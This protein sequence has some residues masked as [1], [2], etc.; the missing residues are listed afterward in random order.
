MKNIP[1]YCVI[2]T[3]KNY[4]YK[5]ATNPELHAGSP[6]YASE[7]TELWD[8]IFKKP[9]HKVRQELKQISFTS[10]READFDKVYWNLD[11]F[12]DDYE[13][14]KTK[15]LVY[16]QDDDDL[17]VPDIATKIKH[18][19]RAGFDG[20]VWG[21]L[22]LHGMYNYYFTDIEKGRFGINDDGN[23]MEVRFNPF[24]F[25]QSNHNVTLYPI[26][27][28][29]TIGTH[30]P[31][32]DI[33]LPINHSCIH[34][35]LFQQSKRFIRINDILSVYNSTPASTTYLGDELNILKHEHAKEWFENSGK[36]Y[37]YI[38]RFSTEKEKG[39]IQALP[40]SLKRYI[41]KTKNIFKDC[42]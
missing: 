42:L 21:H 19:Y 38:E 22:R 27:K 23:T 15:T 31:S 25:I 17:V 34:W 11:D 24:P 40:E 4:E 12:F 36:F 2:R 33:T 14:I 29:N 26:D 28:L 16:M 18:N 5:E 8:G 35:Y 20:L 37:Q 13:N 1:V 10:I 41:T 6:T 7:F 3:D 9:Y 30:I 32:L 39:C